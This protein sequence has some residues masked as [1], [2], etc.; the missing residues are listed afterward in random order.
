MRTANTA[1]RKALLPMLAVA[2]AAATALRA[3]APRLD[4]PANVGSELSLNGPWEV[5][6]DRHYTGQAAVPGLAQDP[7]EMS[8]GMLWYKRAVILPPGTWKQATLRLNG[9]R[10]APVVYVNG[11][12]VSSSEGGM[13]PTEHVLDDPTVGPGKEIQLEVALQ[14]LRDLSSGDASAVPLADRWRSDNSSGLWDSVSLH[15]SGEARL[16][17]VVPWT[18]LERDSVT[19][20]WQTRGSE[21]GSAQRT[22]QALL[23]DFSGRVLATSARTE[24]AGAEGRTE[25]PLQ[26]ACKAWTPDAPHIY[27]LRLELRDQQRLLDSRDLTWGLRDFRTEGRGFVL[28]GEPIRLRGGTVVW[29]R[30]V[31]DPEARTVAFD[32]RWFEKQVVLR[33][34]HLGANTLRFHLGLPP[35][36]LLDLC[37]RDGLMVQLEW[38]FFHGV[39][40][41]AESMRRQWRDWLDLAMRHPSVVLI[42]PWNETEGDAL[43]IAW[44][45]LEAILPD[46][47]PLVISH[48]DVIHIHKYW[49]SLFENLG[50]Y[51]DSADQFDRPIM[52]DEFG[53]NYLDGKGDPGLYPAVRES[54]LRFLGREQTRDLRLQFQAEANA[55]VA[56]YWRRLG[57]AGFSPFCILGSPQDG[58]TWFLGSPE[59]PEPKPVWAEL[60]AP[61]SP[62]S[63]SLEVWDRNYSPGQTVQ[64]PLYLFNDTGQSEELRAAV[65]IRAGQKARRVVSS[66]TIVQAVAAHSTRKIEVQMRMPQEAGEWRLEA[67]LANR[68]SG[69]T[70]SILST[71]RCR[72]LEVRVPAALAGV[73][74]GVPP[75][76]T[77]LRAFLAQ[78]GIKA[79]SPE[80]RQARVLVMSAPTWA[81]LPGS[82]ALQ[83]TFRDALERGQSVVLLDVGPRNLGQG[84]KH[85]ELGPLEGAPRVASPRVEHYDLFSGIQ[86]TFREAA[87]PESHLHPAQDNASLWCSLPRQS[88]WLWN[89]LRGGLVV[90]AAD[91]E[92]TGLSANAFVSLWVSRGADAAAI[93]SA[94]NYYAYELAGFYDF[95]T[96][97]KDKVLM[98]R[99]REKVKLLAEDAPALQDRINPNAPVEGL[100][101]ARAF[102]GSG[103]EGMAT[104]LIPLANCGKNLTR[105]P[106][107]ELAFGPAKGKLILS[108]VL[109]A[110]RLV[111]GRKEPGLYGLRYDPAAEQWALNLMAQALND[112]NTKQ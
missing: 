7:G 95:S 62:L 31:R 15:F 94:T 34:K 68:V 84:Y 74:A 29:H 45:A 56:E 24:A 92:V 3:E 52:V 12:K 89:G 14:S 11:T 96:Q 44:S 86:V 35:E 20:H 102:R 75:G 5:G 73:A 51:Y 69:V 18:D 57:A 40:A 76:E 28:N 105:V 48:R 38:P 42:H 108:Q 100:D 37:D 82:T 6:I 30:W 27:R 66:Q 8:P 46:Y 110:G 88:T 79:V 67:G 91:M 21:S 83:R 4:D 111:R 77:E 58:N 47:P 63:L 19:I 53:G 36:A 25:L 59:Y 13:A 49:W 41:S 22:L 17:R 65:L 10:F 97:E 87:E 104:R 103:V 16:T 112:D 39:V 1:I 23:L 26:H 101:I 78:N 43:K 106:V 33:L 71:W 61:Y 60:A 107:V 98:A 80:E 93:R 72:T 9:A 85:G 70:S 109:T 55:K 32:S 90:P 64:L 81:T 54:F 2:A 99:L 50:L